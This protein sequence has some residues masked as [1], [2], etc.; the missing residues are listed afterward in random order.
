MKI[1][2]DWIKSICIGTVMF[3]CQ[4]CFVMQGLWVGSVS[5]TLERFYGWDSEWYASILQNGYRSTVPPQIQQKSTSNVAFFPGYV[6]AASLFY[7]L[8]VQMKWSL[9]LSSLMFAWTFWIL[10]CYALWIPARSIFLTLSS[11]ILFLIYPFS[12]YL[13]FAYSESLY[14]SSVLAFWIFSQKSGIASRSIA[15]LSGFVM[16]GTRLVSLPL[17]ILN[18]QWTKW[19]L[20]RVMVASSGALLFFVYCYLNWGQWNLYFISQELSWN[21]KADYFAIFKSKTW[22]LPQ[23]DSW[24]LKDWNMVLVNHLATTI[25]LWSFVSLV[26]LHLLFTKTKES[27]LRSL[28]LLYGIGI[29]LFVVISGLYSKDFQSS[30]RYMLPIL[31]FMLIWFSTNFRYFC[32]WK[33]QIIQTDLSKINFV[34]ILVIAAA[35]L[36]MAMKALEF[37]QFLFRLFVS[38]YFIA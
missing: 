37:Q 34:L 36:Q 24:Q 35:F 10:F 15:S 11:L 19:G 4:L 8:D 20:L 2:S 28:Y 29:S 21:L 5:A 12:F 25:F 30:A 27:I 7:K 38:G 3:L 32:E 6:I 22:M 33:N 13:V 9:I 14:L 16:T 17:V 26:W 18:L 31:M 23:I 1:E